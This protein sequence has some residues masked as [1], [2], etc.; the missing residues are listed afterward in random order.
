MCI[1]QVII[2]LAPAKNEVLASTISSFVLMV[3][4][5]RVAKKHPRIG[6]WTLG[7]A[8]AAGMAVAVIF[9]HLVMGA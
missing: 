3:V 7:I 2:G 5:E 1:N 6:E 4:L 8:M 9:K